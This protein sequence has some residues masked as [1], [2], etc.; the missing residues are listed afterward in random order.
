MFIELKLY[1][2]IRAALVI[3]VLAACVSQAGASQRPRGEVTRPPSSDAATAAVSPQDALAAARAIE[4]RDERINLLQKFLVNYR[5]SAQEAEAREMLM[6]ELALRGEQRLREG[7][8]QKAS[9]DFKTIFRVTSGD[10]TDRVFDQYIFPLPVAMN[11]FGYRTEAVALMRSFEARFAKEPARLVQIGF[12][13]VQVEAPVEAVRILERSVELAPGDHRAHNSLGAA[14]LINLRL[15]DAEQEFTKA[16]ELDAADEYANLNL[17]NMLR[18]HGDYARAAALYSKQIAV[19][20][21]DADAHG[22]LAISLLALGRDEEAERELSRASRLGPQNYRFFTQLAYYYAAHR[23]PQQAR[24]A[25]EQAAAIEPRFAWAFI[26]KANIDAI[27]GK[28][29]DGLSTLIMAQ[30]LGTFPTLNFELSKILM[31]LDGYDQALDVLSKAIAVTEDGEFEARLG[32]VMRARSPRLDLL[33]ERER[34]AALFFNEPLTTTMQYRL[35]ESLFRFDHYQKAALAARAKKGTPQ[36]EAPKTSKASGARSRPTR[37][38]AAPPATTGDSESQAG[39]RARRVQEKAAPEA[40]LSAGSDAGIAGV[41]EMIRAI[42]EFTSLDDGR[43]AFRMVWV[44]HRLAENGLALDAAIELALRA[45]SVADPATEPGGSMRDAPLLDREGRKAVF[46]G[47]AEDA[48]GWA[49]FKKGDTRGALLHLSRSVDI[50]PINNERKGA[51]W[52]LGVA[53]EEAGDERRALDFYI[54]SYDPSSPAWAGR[55]VQIEA[56]YKKLTGT[57]NGLDD[58][59]KGR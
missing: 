57:L 28:Y 38:P 27:D 10:I 21:D 47:R 52:H 3:S 5:G 6:R 9:E 24:V 23:K 34:Q 45:I 14:Y 13:Y 42:T 12:F 36:R 16:A 20:S 50:Y 17:A 31:L 7:D 46:L 4:S 15:D 19:K 29:G 56:L 37:T 32:G 22:G 25:I 1:R 49:L 33:L 58:R 39:A 54:A 26:T 53:T 2:R 40:P 59:L 11:A 8:P 43:Q 48:L 41:P 35:A 55:R 18:A 30:Q 44:A 51:L